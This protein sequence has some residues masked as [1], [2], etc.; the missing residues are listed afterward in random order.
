MVDVSLLSSLLQFSDQMFPRGAFIAGS[1]RAHPYTFAVVKVPQPSYFRQNLMNS[2]GG[3]IDRFI[4]TGRIAVPA[5][6]QPTLVALKRGLSVSSSKT[7]VTRAGT[8]SPSYSFKPNIIKFLLLSS[9]AATFNVLL[10]Q[11]TVLLYSCSS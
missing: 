8:S 9:H 1:I 6:F 10:L 4:L 7:A 5:F 11:T 2:G 3:I